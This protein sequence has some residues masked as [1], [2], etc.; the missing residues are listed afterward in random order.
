[1]PS[2]KWSSKVH[3]S[4]C[5]R[6]GALRT[7]IPAGKG[8]SYHFPDGLGSLEHRPPCSKT[9]ESRRTRKMGRRSKVM[10]RSRAGGPRLLSVREVN[11]RHLEAVLTDPVITGG[12]EIQ[13]TM[14][15]DGMTRA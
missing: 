10:A 13:A 2:H 12:V 8:W 6:C 1:M 9:S 15:T 5:S 3:S 11:R 7:V 14:T 4:S